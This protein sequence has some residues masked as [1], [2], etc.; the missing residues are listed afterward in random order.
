MKSPWVLL[1]QSLDSLRREH[2]SPEQIGW[3]VGVGV[4]VGCSPFLGLH[5]L[6]ALGLAT[7]LR[8]NRLAVV[9]G[10]Q[11]SMP[12][13]TPL[14][15]LG[16][17]QLGAWILTGQGMTLTLEQ[18]RSTPARVLAET[19]FWRLLVGGAVIG[20]VLAAVLGWG[21][22]ALLRRRLRETQRA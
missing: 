14:L 7:L 22:T 5:M 9:L 4:W 6:L 3:A 20:G 13:L 16:N 2:A 17:A 18:I 8:L 21:T 10:T 11:I 1:R 15:L 19:L 12:P